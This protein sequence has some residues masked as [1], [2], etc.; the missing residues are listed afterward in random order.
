M[1][2]KLLLIP[3]L[4][5]ATACAG[6]SGLMG[7]P[8]QAPAAVQNISRSA[9]DFALHSFDAALYGID[10]ALDT[11][12]IVP[13]SDTARRLAATGRRV[14]NFLG[15][16][17]AA[18]DLGNSATYE[19]AFQNANAA[20][21]EFRSLFRPQAAAFAWSWSPPPR[22]MS[23]AERERILARLEGGGPTT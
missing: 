5:A 17:E 11:G 8:P 19:Q 6:L 7:P 9:L 2:R 3:L 18:R 4:A 16:A 22:P 23:D 12:R 20:L 13:G 10:V 15:A 21:T 1:L 14:M